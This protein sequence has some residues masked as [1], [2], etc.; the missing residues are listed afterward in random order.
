[1]QTFDDYGEITV[2]TKS[3][4]QQIWDVLQEAYG[5]AGCPVG[6]TWNKEL[7]KQELKHGQGI[8]LM[9]PK[10]LT[11]F[12]LYRHF[13]EHREITALATHPSRQKK[14]DMRYL[15]TYL[16][17]RRS[18]SERI[19]LEVHAENTPA[20][21]LYKNLGF[22][23]VGRRPRYYRDGGDAVLFHLGTF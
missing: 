20:Q 23:E 4:G 1:M 10:G 16:I 18:P 2:L 9:G 3:H 5:S 14:G 12:V 15:L 22:E 7:L 21:H 19:W 6:G 13:D 17:E 11:S 8:G